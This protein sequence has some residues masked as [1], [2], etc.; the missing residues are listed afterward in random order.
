MLT[1]EEES[2]D[3]KHA[4]KLADDGSDGRTSDPH[5][6]ETEVAEDE[7]RIQDDIRDAAT[8]LEIMGMTIFPVA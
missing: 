7:D 3:D 5:R 4:Q 6:R 1:K 8:I 2:G